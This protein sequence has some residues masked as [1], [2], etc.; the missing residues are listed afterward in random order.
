VVADETG[1]CFIPR[2]RAADVLAR[3]LEKA[4]FEQRKCDAIDAGVSV[5][6]LP[7]NA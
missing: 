6:D 1:V 5:A 3:A 4:A 2:E 7:T